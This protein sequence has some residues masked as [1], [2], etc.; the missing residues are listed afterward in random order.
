M[1]DCNS[2]LSEP[3][4]DIL[5]HSLLGGTRAGRDGG[6]EARQWVA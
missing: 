4:V 5:C 3:G 2:L 1:V 6:T